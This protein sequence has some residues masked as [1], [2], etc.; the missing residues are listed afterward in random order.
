MAGTIEVTRGVRWSAASWLFDWVLNDLSAT[1]QDAAT[2]Q[3]LQEIVRVNLG[4]LGIEDL[5]EAGR[6]EVLGAL[7]RSLVD[8]SDR[9]LPADLPNRDDVL[10]HLQ[11]L[12]DLACASSTPNLASG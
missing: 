3:K 4:W 8:Y 2:V 1:V 5:P 9:G 12:A 11:E 10:S 7:C 6:A